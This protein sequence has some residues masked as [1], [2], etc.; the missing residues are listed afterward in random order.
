MRTMSMYDRAIQDL[1]S[2]IISN[3]VDHEQEVLRL[4]DIN[5]EL[6]KELEPHRHLEFMDSQGANGPIKGES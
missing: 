5:R 1:K 4:K 3:A 6:L 2:K